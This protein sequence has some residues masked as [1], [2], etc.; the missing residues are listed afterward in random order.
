MSGLPDPENQG[1]IPNA[2]EHIFGC[3]DDDGNKDKKYLV[4]CSYI[5]I[6]NE[7]IRDLLGLNVEQKLDLKEDP[8]KGVF[9]KDLSIKTVKS[10]KEI[11][12]FMGKGNSL[13]KVGATAMNDTSSRSHS[14]FTIYIETAEHVD[15]PSNGKKQQRFK[16]GKLNLVDLA[17][18][19][20]QSK[21]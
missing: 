15:D 12:S 1:I 20:R 13:R 9:V 10:V 18:S 7:E 3:I 14:L 19:E 17:G 11:E 2:F 6:Y 16:A 21:T 5:E 8:N 4:R